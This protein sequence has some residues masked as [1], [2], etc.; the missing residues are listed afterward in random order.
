MVLCY[1][2]ERSCRHS[3]LDVVAVLSKPHAP[4]HRVRV[5]HNDAS[6]AAL[7]SYFL[8]RHIDFPVRVSEVA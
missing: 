5:I 8:I 4:L 7:Q 1:A 3:D 2:E 6:L